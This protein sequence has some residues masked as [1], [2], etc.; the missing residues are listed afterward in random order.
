MSWADLLIDSCVVQRYAA[1]AI[2]AYGVPA[3]AWA[4]HIG[5]TPCRIVPDKGTEVVVGAQVVIAEYTLF[6]GGDAD[7]IE[8]DRVTIDG[9]LYEVLLVQGR[10]D[11]IGR[12]HQ[13]CLLRTVR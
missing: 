13:E 6:I 3:K 1:G 12:H 8:Q 11:S 2:D 5:A 7:I 9:V 4:L 10:S